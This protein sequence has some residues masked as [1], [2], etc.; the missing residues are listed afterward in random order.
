M[1]TSSTQDLLDRYFAAMNAQEDFSTFFAED[2]TWTMVDTDQEVRG[3]A[4]VRDHIL[5]LHSRMRGGRQRPLVVADS[6]AVLEGEAVDGEDGDER[7]LF[8]C[9]VYDLRDDRISAMRCYGS[10]SRLVEGQV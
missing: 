4:A 1:S 5:V 3:A 10:L 9:L 6:H 2:V 7:G 8:F